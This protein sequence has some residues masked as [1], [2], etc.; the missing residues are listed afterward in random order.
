MNQG[1]KKGLLHTLICSLALPLTAFAAE[2][3]HK[4]ELKARAVYWN[5]ESVA[6]PS[7]STPNPKPSSYEQSAL[8]LQLNYQSPYWADF[9]GFDASLYGVT[10]TG[11]SGTPT[12]NLLEVGNNGRVE[13]SY[14]TAAQALIKLKY[15]D[16]A[17]LKVGR[18][19][20][21]GLLLRSTNTRAVPD[22]YSGASAS[23]KPFDGLTIY[24]AIYDQW[25][26]RST[27]EFEKFRTEATKAGVA[28]AIDYISIVGA[29]YA[30]GPLLVT[31][32]YLNSKSYLSKFGL[33]GAYTIPLDKNS[34]KLSSGLFT[35]R[36]AGSL[37]VC[38]AERDLD[39]G[40]GTQRISNDGM[41]VYIDGEWKLSNVTI[42]AA[43]A[44]FDGFWIEDNFAVNATRTGGLTQDHGT[45]PFPTA[46]GL[47][48]DL[49]NRDELVGSVRLGYDFKDYIRGLKA[50]FKYAQGTGA[51]S[52]NQENLAVG[53]ENYREFNLQYAIPF[54]KN[55]S[56]RYAYMN[57][58]SHI[59]NGSTTATIK[60]MSRQDWEQH[61]L[62]IDYSYQF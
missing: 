16:T 10:K 55:L 3:E 21:N 25:R 32:E 17:Q 48:P 30:N 51:K 1:I 54:V 7:S 47:G 34:L 23:V 26:S 18:Q 2:G 59:K 58:D 9:I 11:S 33:V 53:S 43:V 22:T 40:T 5:D 36:D 31:A 61:R 15:Q 29:S 6:Y 57:Y 28:N 8:G 4:L 60:G 45:N 20:Q 14:V 52:S 39:C 38:S 62:Y 46:A 27:G 49:S 42:G 24:G 37:F 56:A 35:S 44:K 19:I 41:G 50:A 13:D 12:T